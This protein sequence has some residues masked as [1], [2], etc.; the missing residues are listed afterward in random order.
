MLTE[1]RLAELERAAARCVEGGHPDWVQ[2][3]R[4]DELAEL[5]R[6]ARYGHDGAVVRKVTYRADG[7]LLVRKPDGR[8]RV[9]PA[10]MEF[11]ALGD[12]GD[13]TD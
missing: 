7:A 2:S 11:G 8:E 3:L 5:C 4:A 10:G 9:L 13:E 6:A 1:E 12:D